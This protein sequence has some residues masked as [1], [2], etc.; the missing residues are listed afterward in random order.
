[1]FPR[2]APIIN[3]FGVRLLCVYPVVQVWVFFVE[4]Y[5][6]APPCLEQGF[7]SVYI[8]KRKLFIFDWLPIF[9]QGGI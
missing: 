4:P 6:F 9:V 7:V 5:A 2:Q 3:T 1:M 8:G